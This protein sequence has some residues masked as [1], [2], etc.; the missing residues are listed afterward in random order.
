MS[1]YVEGGQVICL[2]FNTYLNTVSTMCCIMTQAVHSDVE[3]QALPCPPPPPAQPVVECG[4]LQTV[5]CTVVQK[6]LETQS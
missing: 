3:L 4:S 5:E 2:S 1:M 6:K